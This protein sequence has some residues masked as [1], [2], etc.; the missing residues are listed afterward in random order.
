MSDIIA[1]L[2]WINDAIFVSLVNTILQM[3]ILI[4]VV[5][6]FIWMFRIR[7]P[8]MRYSLWLFVL[9]A[10]IALP[11]IT[12]F[13]SQI[14]FA[15]F[16]RQGVTGDG[17]DGRLM[18]EST[19][20]GEPSEFG[21]SL[22]PKSAPK[23][24]VSGEMDVS[25]INP[26]SVAYFIWLEAMLLIL[27][28]TAVAYIRLKKLRT[29]SPD[30]KD[31]AVLEMLSK[32]KRRI[33]VKKSVALKASSGI[34]TPMSLGILSTV[35]IVPDSIMDDDSKDELEMILAHELAHI[36]R[37]DYLVNMLQNAMRAI[38]FFHPLFHLMNRSLMKERE[39]ICDD[40]VI[41]ITKQ[42]NQYA[43]C[44]VSLLERVVYRPV[45]DPVVIAMAERRR[46]I[47]G[48]IHMIIDRKRKIAT[49]ASGKALF[50][51]ILI[52][53]LSLPIIGGLGLLE[54]AGIK[55]ALAWAQVPEKAQIAFSAW[56]NE[57]WELYVMD[58]DGGNQRELTGSPVGGVGANWS[59]ASQRFAFLSGRDGNG[60]IYVMDA[61]GNNQRN[62]TNNP[63]ADDL[64]AWS[65]D[66]QR[67]VFGS[68]RDGSHGIYV[69]DSDGSNQ[70]RLIDTGTGGDV[71]SDWSPDGQRIIFN[72]NR[73]GNGEI[74]VMDVDGSNPHN[75]TNSLAGDGWGVW[76]PDGQRIAFMSD[77]DGNWE[78]YVMDSDGSNQ[79]RLTDN[80]GDDMVPSWSPD[81]QRITFL[82]NRDGNYEVYVMDVDG[83]NQHNLTNSP[84]ND[85]LAYW[86]APDFT[87]SVS[88]A[89]KLKSTWGKI[90]RR[91][92]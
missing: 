61:D 33:G 46:D 56:R 65:P 37:Y 35:I 29:C 11:L 73:D 6:L 41:D 59:P 71:R 79:R 42:R 87:T 26:V 64:P 85:N 48:R 13:V 23:A 8:T 72:S 4:S 53:C 86:F 89:G 78:T 5:A 66:G 10:M 15:R 91:L 49:R 24:T 30:V 39:H 31:S 68:M 32:L 1:A 22:P 83:N 55:T 43:Q 52:G 12:P 45:S 54:I 17:L 90:K 88:P 27:C 38:F 50:A 36:R 18:M 16:R 51:V 92:R 82:S 69:M 75:L 9:F 67:I 84:T 3:T 21:V 34:Y 19:Y 40:W 58:A 47:P 80:P 74:Y 2:S 14:D 25:L 77:R 62:L 28:I 70:R 76:S 57:S 44:M 60:E 63:G 7:T 81:G 20:E